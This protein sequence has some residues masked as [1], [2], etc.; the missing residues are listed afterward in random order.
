VSQFVLARIVPVVI[1]AG[2]LGQQVSSGQQIVQSK[3][4]D[5]KVDYAALVKY[6]PWDDRN[7]EL[8]ATDLKL[9]PANEEKI[10][11]PLPAFF[12]VRMRKD[13]PELQ[14]EGSEYPRSATQIFFRQFGGY[15]INGK[16][17]QRVD[18]RDGKYVVIQENGIDYKKPP[19]DS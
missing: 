18:L 15:L 7:Y 6:G 12:R 1:F 4:K 10:A 11:S 19:P 2:C 13:S 17:Y 8:T 16:L 14:R 5:P 9:L 3:G